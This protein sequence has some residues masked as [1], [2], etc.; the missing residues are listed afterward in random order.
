L[1]FCIDV[2]SGSCYYTVGGRQVDCGNCQTN[3]DAISG[4]VQRAVELCI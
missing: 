3:P 1:D 4:C 2:N